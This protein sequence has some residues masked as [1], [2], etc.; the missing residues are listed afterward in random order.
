MYC[1]NIMSV[2]LCLVGIGLALVAL[3]AHKGCNQLFSWIGLFGNA[4]VIMGVLGVYV[5]S[6]LV[7]ARERQEW[8]RPQVPPMPQWPAPP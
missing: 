4:V 8:H 7:A 2:P 5:H 6:Q 3:I 1:F